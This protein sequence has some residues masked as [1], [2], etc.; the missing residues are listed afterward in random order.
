MSAPC[1]SPVLE[2]DLSGLADS[3]TL[4]WDFTA[5]LPTS[6][7]IDPASTPVVNAVPPSP[8]AVFSNVV[9]AS[10]VVTARVTITPPAA[11]GLLYRT[12]CTIQTAQGNQFVGKGAFSTSGQLASGMASYTTPGLVEC[13]LGPQ[14]Y[15]GTTDLTQ[16]VASAHSLCQGINTFA[17][18]KGISVLAGPDLEI[19]ER[20]LSAHLYCQNNPALSSLS[21]GGISQGFQGQSTLNLDN[22]RWGQMAIMMDTTGYLNM[23][24]NRASASLVWLG[25][26][27][28][29]IATTR[30]VTGAFGSLGGPGGGG[31]GSFGSIP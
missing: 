27:C 26:G 31:N 9:V 1:C 20:W 14:N 23:I 18:N 25:V 13:L 28:R 30:G 7:S 15:D 16:F 12:S 22:T 3:V 19:V 29:G 21:T 4:S 2:V 11:S 17:A 6:D 5:K 24:N 10:P 8:L